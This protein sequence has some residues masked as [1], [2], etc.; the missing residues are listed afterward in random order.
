MS[1]GFTPAPGVPTVAVPCPVCL[2]A[3][4]DPC[5]APDDRGRHAVNRPHLDRVPR[6]SYPSRYGVG[7]PDPLEGFGG[8]L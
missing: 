4:G 2:A 1:A 7:T 5:T 6:S 3:P 8:V